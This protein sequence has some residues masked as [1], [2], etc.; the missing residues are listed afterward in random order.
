MK[1]PDFIIAMACIFIANKLEECRREEKC[2][3]FFFEHI[4]QIK[5]K[6]PLETNRWNKS[7]K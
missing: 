4:S 2:V 6:G 5:F 1:Y 3:E 7:G